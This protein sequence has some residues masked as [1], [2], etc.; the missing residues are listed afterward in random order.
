MRIK[1]NILE[2]LRNYRYFKLP[3]LTAR[4]H[5]CGSLRL[6]LHKPHMAILYRPQDLHSQSSAAVTHYILATAHLPTPEYWNPES[7]LSAPGIEPR[8]PAHMSEYASGRP[9][10]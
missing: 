4:K 8:P 2:R 5:A 9:T 6:R 1:K 7:R 3:T 10:I